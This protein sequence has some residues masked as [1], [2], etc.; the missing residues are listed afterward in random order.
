MPNHSRAK[1]DLLWFAAQIRP[2]FRNLVLSM[3]L[4][5]SS[6]LMFLLDPLV[7]KWMLDVV[8][9]SGDFRLLAFCVGGLLVIYSSRLGL[10]SLGRIINFRTAQRLAFRLRLRLLDKINGLSADFHETMPVGEKLFRIEQDVDQVAEFGSFVPHLLQAAFNLLFVI[11]AMS[12][13][14]FRLVLGIAPLLAFAIYIAVR[15]QN[16]LRSSAEVA[17]ERGGLESSFLQEHLA[18]VVQVQLL[19]GEHGQTESFRELASARMNALDRRNRVEVFFGAWYMAAIA[20]GTLAVLG[21]GGHQVFAGALSIGGLVAFYT[22]LARVFDPL[23]STVDIYARFT[24]V[25]ASIGRIIEIAEQAP[26]IRESSNAV[27]LPHRNRG[28]VRLIDA[29]FAYKPQFPV[30]SYL[31]L[32]ILQGEKVALV[33]FSGSGK[34]TVAKLIARLYDVQAGTVEVNGV[35]VRHVKLDSLRAN[36]SYLMQEAIL[37]DRSLK[38]NLLLGCPD[39]TDEQVQGA[40]EIAELQDLLSRLPN[41]WDTRIGPRGTKISGGE[42]Q[43][44]ILARTLLKKPAVLL[45]DEATSALDAPAER[46]ILR[47]LSQCLQH[48]SIVFI[49]HR[50][51]SLHWV[52]RIAV[53]HRGAIEEQGS[54]SE[55]IRKGCLYMSLA[56]SEAP[57]DK[58]R[59]PSSGV[60]LTHANLSLPTD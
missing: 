9:P 56:N 40:L 11:V 13:L 18:S 49:S 60:G 1:D 36:V 57:P 4:I 41:G 17:Q 47:N 53:L 58:A 30:L 20:A 44:V 52:D 31:A 38:E 16:R 2:F 46:R 6:S 10:F 43:R 21:Y 34:S 35:D 3:L 15:Y 19:N 39:A 27:S 24:R 42:R 7:L 50:I 22:Y 5:A 45:L 25:R 8:L 23:Y 54:H 59:K 55:L 14:N 28:T 32:E 51:S 48:Q 37:F 33:G 29:S 12:I 26:S